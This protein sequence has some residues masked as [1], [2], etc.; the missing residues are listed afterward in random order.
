MQYA[1][2]FFNLLIGCLLLLV[3]CR[4]TNLTS[5]Q[6]GKKSLTQNV[7]TIKYTPGTSSFIV[8]NEKD[9]RPLLTQE[10]QESTRPYIHPIAAPD[11]KGILTQFSPDHHKHQTGLY[12]GLKEVNGRDYFMN[13]KEDYWQKVSA[14]VVV[15]EGNQVKWQT[16]YNLLDE[17]K[18]PLLTETQTWAMQQQEGKYLVDLEW[19]GEA[20]SEVE[21]GKFYV[22][23]LFLRMPW[24]KGIHG[25]VINANGQR[26]QEAEGQRAIWADIGIQV[27]GRNDLAHIAIFDHPDNAV[28]PTPWRVDNEL[29]IGPSR[30]ILGDWKIEKGKR[31]IFRYRLVIYTGEL[32]HAELAQQWKQYI[33]EGY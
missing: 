8:T 22:G 6:P 29:G 10:A 30:Q 25:E 4:N 11:G 24:Y 12:W 19:K 28:F 21:I 23:G 27:E 32:N 26:N 1:M 14:A 2:P 3:G 5:N 9:D 13:W 18:Q 15:A 16:V 20:K 17:N 31:A 7:L 33:C